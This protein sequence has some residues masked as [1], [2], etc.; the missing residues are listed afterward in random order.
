MKTRYFLLFLL[1]IVTVST[2]KAQNDNTTVYFPTSDTEKENWSTQKDENGGIDLIYNGNRR[3]T[4]I[5]AV[6]FVD[7]GVV[8]DGKRVKFASLNI[9]AKNPWE[10]GNYYVSGD[11]GD[12]IAAQTFG[13]GFSM[14]TAD[15]WAALYNN[16]EWKWVAGYNGTN[17]NG[18]AVFKRKASGVYSVE[19][20]KHIFLPASGGENNG[21]VVDAGKNGWYW[22]T[23]AN[24]GSVL[25]FHS[26]EISPS[27][28]SNLSYAFP[29][30]P[31]IKK[32]ASIFL[33]KTDVML[34]VNGKEK[35]TA[36]TPNSNGKTVVWKSDDES[37]AK[38]DA[39]GNVT[40]VSTGV[41]TITATIGNETITC[42]VTVKI[43]VTG[44]TLSGAE[45]ANPYIWGSENVLSKTFT[46][47]VTPDNAT[48]KTV[49]WE[50]SHPD[51]IEVSQ[52][53]EVK[54]IAP[55]ETG[56]VLDVT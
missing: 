39:N 10:A 43:P 54:I 44:V 1:L 15:D 12:D 40:G 32:T 30:R 27:E 29:V 5:Y 33:D 18:Y 34:S 31:V 22:S 36:T 16:C 38:V 52:S 55:N 37:I 2:V 17:A 48:D 51:I 25:G 42:I 49:T 8:V 21:K 28:T 50:S 13:S 46:A 4:D 56:G 6:R 3:V 20:D 9:G 23:P 14:P 41:T 26:T 11:L 35:L 7:L 24:Q 53:G 19:K 47:A 45:Y